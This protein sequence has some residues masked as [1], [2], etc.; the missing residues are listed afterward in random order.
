M[1][2][3]IETPEDAGKTTPVEVENT[4]Y[5]DILHPVPEATIEAVRY[6]L[7]WMTKF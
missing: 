5:Y 3:T 2:R 1:V 7:A 4:N 6:S